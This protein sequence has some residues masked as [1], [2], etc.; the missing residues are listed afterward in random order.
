M[1]MQTAFNV[2]VGLAGALGGFFLKSIWDA[3]KDVQT[4]DTAMAADIT[5]LKVLV[6]GNYVTRNEYRDDMSG[7]KD[8]LKRIEDKLDSK[9]DKAK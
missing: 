1:D 8:A 3:I 5:S 9:A 6:A 7:I 4:A 2:A